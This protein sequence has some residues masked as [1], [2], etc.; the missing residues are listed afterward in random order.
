MYGAIYDECHGQ[1]FTTCPAAQ[2]VTYVNYYT[3]NLTLMAPVAQIETWNDSGRH[4]SAWDCGSQIVLKDWFGPQ[5]WLSADRRT[6]I[7]TVGFCMAGSNYVWGFSFLFSLIVCVL[8]LAFTLLM[9]GI[10]ASIRSH[11][12]GK[13]E[14]AHSLF[15]DA[16]FMI[17]SAQTQYGGQIREWSAQTLERDIV[18]GKK[19]LSLQETSYVRKRRSHKDLGDPREGDWGGNV[20]S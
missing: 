10:W 14:P 2:V 9:Y 15:R 3:S 7:Q 11:S 17:T 5:G 4:Y 18:N 8:H 13:R 6:N 12:R 16:T 20:S 19:G 1:N